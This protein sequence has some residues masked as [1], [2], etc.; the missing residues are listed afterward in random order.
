[1]AIA[2]GL[3][4][5]GVPS[6][7]LW[8]VLAGL[9]R[10]V[11]PLLHGHSTGLS[12]MSVIV[13]AVFWTWMWGPVGLILSTPL[14]L[15]LV[16]M[17]R[18]VKSLEFFDVLLGDRSAL[19]EVNRFYQRTLANDPDEALDQAEQM[20]ADRSLVDLRQRR[21]ARAEARRG[22]RGP[23]HDQSPARCGNDPLH[24]GRH[25]RPQRACR[26][27]AH[28]N[29]IEATLAALSDPSA[30]QDVAPPSSSADTAGRSDT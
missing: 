26:C 20:L 15:C 17:G 2:V 23:R 9:L 16:V 19:S 8:G 13:A 14:T 11:E 21:P 7:A 30:S 6:A 10:F 28:G 1:V 4:L 3:R 5:I 18:R 12:S 27:T 29:P 22:R 24:P 25:R